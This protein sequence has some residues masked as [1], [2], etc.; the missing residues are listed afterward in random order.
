MVQLVMPDLGGPDTWA[1]RSRIVT[2]VIAM[3]AKEH[4][5]DRAE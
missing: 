3:T 2:D 1:T 4:A 5:E